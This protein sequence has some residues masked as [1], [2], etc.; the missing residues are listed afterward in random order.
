M[1]TRR[2]DSGTPDL[3]F[4]DGPHVFV[5][6]LD[7]PELVDDDRHHLERSLR[8]RT[9]DPLTVSDGNDRWRAAR[10]GASLDVVGAIVEVPAPL[11]PVELAVALTKGT[12]PELAVQKATELG[13]D[14]IVVF[15]AD[16]S[17]AR[18]VG[19]KVERSVER[20]RRVAREAAMQSRQVRL[21]TVEFV[22]EL[23]ALDDGRFR[24][25]DFGGSGIDATTTSIAIGPEGG[26]SERERALLARTV[27]LG[28]TVLRAETAAIAA[29]TQMTALRARHR[30][31][32]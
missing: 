17:V 12:K 14:R 24:R 7:A 4:A 8:L 6:D 10:F 25:A 1:S 27:D 26:W 18:W 21:P 9:G 13:V 22:A 11:W 15:S 5:T 20:L 31:A 29:A 2:D 19:D 32:N 28:P 23:T 30:N 16:H 3:R